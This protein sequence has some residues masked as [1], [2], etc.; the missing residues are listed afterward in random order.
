MASPHPHTR[1]DITV[2]DVEYLRHPATGPLLATVYRPRGEGPFPLIL[3][4]HGGAWCRG[5]RKDDQPLCEPLARSGVVVAALDFRQPP[6]A[7]YPGSMID[8]NYAIRWFKHHAGRFGARADR[9]GVMG[10]SSGGQQAILGAMRHDDPRYA[11]LPSPAGANV[12]ATVKCVVLCWPVIDP[13]GRYQYAK[14]LIADRSPHAEVG[15]R[16]IPSHDQYWGSEAAM[17]EGS[18]T[19]ALERGERGPTPPVLYVQGTAD[20]AHPRPNLDRFVKAYR[21]A[22]GRVDLRFFEGVGEAFIKKDPDSPQSRA[23]LEAIADFV[24]RELA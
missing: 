11:S 18:P 24:H 4:L 6:D 5:D 17:A 8:I 10:I 14:Q 16:V 21:D 23:C 12:D 1:H 3:D 9:I 22:G 20:L 13:L 2:E 15:E 7:S 19:R